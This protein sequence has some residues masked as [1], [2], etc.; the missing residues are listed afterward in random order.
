MP[1]D[2]NIEVL[3]GRP[4]R[5]NALAV[6]VAD[7]ADQARQNRGHRGR[8]CEPAAQAAA[9]LPIKPRKYHPIVSYAAPGD[10]LRTTRPIRPSECP[11]SQPTSPGFFT[12]VIAPIGD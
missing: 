7:D 10:P 2:G 12:Q 11:A 1:A 8:S 6:A 5:E 4:G 9:H 3:H